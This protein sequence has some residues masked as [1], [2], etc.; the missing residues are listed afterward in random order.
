M[1]EYG[2]IEDRVRIGQLEYTQDGVVRLHE[3]ATLGLRGVRYRST[4]KE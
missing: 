3:G 1:Y 4:L 2:A